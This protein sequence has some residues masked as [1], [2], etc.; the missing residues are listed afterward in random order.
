MAA[1][2][3]PHVEARLIAMGSAPLMQGFALIGFET[4]PDADEATLEQVLTGLLR[5]R[6]RALLLLEPGLARCECAALRMVLNEG[7]RI[8]VSEI[9]PLEAA[10]AYRPALDELLATTMQG[11][12]QEKLQ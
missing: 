3:V 12:A 7:G 5:E 10:D 6:Q 11:G 2:D 4:W 8:V 1:N 9:P